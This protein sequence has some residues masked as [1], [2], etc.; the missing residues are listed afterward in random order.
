MHRVWI[1]V[2]VV[3]AACGRDAA[4]RT[5]P[6]H[7]A[8]EEPVATSDLTIEASWSGAIRLD[9]ARGP[10]AREAIVVRDDAAYDHLVARLPETRVQ[11]KQP[12]PPS[13]DPLRGRP[14]IDFSTH[15]L[16]VVVHAGT[17]EL[18]AIARVE[19]R[20]DGGLVATY[21]PPP[22]TPAAHPSGFG[23]Y[24]AAKVPRGDG[25]LTLAVPPVIAHQAGLAAAAGE[26]VTLR[27]ELTR[28]RIPTLLGVD[29]DEGTATPGARA[30][31]TGWLEST[32][33]TQAE[34]DAQIARSGQF[35]HRGPGTFHRLVAPDRRGLAAARPAY[36]P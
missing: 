17:L 18:P 7:H 20:D 10:D 31:A 23:A 25:D 28:T 35:A 8:E 12:A 4:P 14:A 22:D 2:V 1:A 6:E 27:G 11:M 30:E 13:D 36:S 24:A 33:I 21:V 34:I 16:V 29:V 19:R 5:P 32:T 9:R 15:M 3:V 26:L